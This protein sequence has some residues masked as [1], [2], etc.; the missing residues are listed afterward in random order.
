[1]DEM[2]VELRTKMKEGKRIQDEL[3][4]PKY[5]PLSE[6]QILDKFKELGEENK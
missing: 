2:S 5:C 1:M 6:K 3:K 4:Q